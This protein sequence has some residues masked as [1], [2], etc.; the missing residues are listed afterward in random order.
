MTRVLMTADTVGGVWTYATEL[1]DALPAYGVEVVLATMGGPL[2]APRAGVHESRYALEWMPD[3][4]DDVDRAGE[5]LLDLARDVRP[6]VVHLNGYAHAALPWG[7]PRVVVA[8]S[9]VLSWHRAV[10]RCEAGPEWDEYR[11]R[12]AAGLDAA[13][14][15]VAPTHAMLAALGRDGA[16]IP[17]GRTA[18]WVRDVPKE[19]FV[20]TA[21]RQWD[22]A[23]NIA[24]LERLRLPLAVAGGC[25]PFGELA[26]LLN[27]AAVFA[28][29]AK[30][31]PFG[32]AALEAGLA[33]CALVLGD[34]PSLREVWGD[35]A[36][37]ADPFDGAAIGRAVRDALDDAPALGAAARR[38]A[39]R[40]TPDAMAAAYAATY[41]RLTSARGAA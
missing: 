12:I 25:L 33:G 18:G 39:A 17:N 40:Y 23:K 35:A 22:E 32:L 10:R 30:Y 8:H 6:D 14:V 11:R 3:P 31:E 26:G 28:L 5:W 15:V 27:R 29:P 16:V 4:W 34:I 20:L 41:G 13:D 7:V 21:G 37:Y 24:A 9:D 2:P 36:L 38:R 1:A 19:P